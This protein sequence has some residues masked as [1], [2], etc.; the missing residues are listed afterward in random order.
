MCK[1]TAFVALRIKKYVFSSQDIT[2]LLCHTG[3]K[4]IESSYNAMHA[5]RKL[6]VLLSEEGRENYSQRVLKNWVKLLSSP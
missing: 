2:P 3:F 4:T 6:V 1:E 5:R